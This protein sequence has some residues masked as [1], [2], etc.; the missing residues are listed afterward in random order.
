MPIQLVGLLVAL[1]GVGYLMVDRHPAENRNVLLLGFLS[2][3]LG[4]LLAITHV[5]LGNLPMVMLVVLFFADGIY[6]VPFWM[7]YRH[8]GSHQRS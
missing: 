3:L 1:F 7:I 6:L 2:K 8:L 5:A 4:P